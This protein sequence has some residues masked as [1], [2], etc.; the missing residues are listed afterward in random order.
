MK[1]WQHGYDIEYLKQLES[2][3]EHYN[4]YSLSPFAKYKK[5]DIAEDL[6]NKNLVLGDGY[7]YV[8]KTTKHDMP[9]NIYHGVRGGFKR[10]GD[11][12]INRLIISDDLKE[13]PLN[14]F[15]S[16]S[17][18]VQTWAEDL[19]T[20]K[21]LED[22]EFEYICPKVTTFGEIYAF[23]FRE[24]KINN[25]HFGGMFSSFTRN[26]I[27]WDP[28]ENVTLQKV[29]DCPIGLIDVCAN[30]FRNFNYE[31]T[32][33]Y[34]NYNKSR[35]WSAFALRG[36]FD[37][38][39]RIE[40]PSELDK[41]HKTYNPELRDTEIYHDFGVVRTLLFEIFGLANFHRIRFMK[42]EPGGG[43]LSRHT[44]QVDVDCGLQRC[45]ITRFHFPI[46]TN[47]DV[48]FNAWN[49]NGEKISL[50]MQPGSYYILDT[51]KPHMVIN[52]GSTPRIHLVVDV[53]VDKL[54]RS[55]L[56]QN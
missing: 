54:I 18:W 20:R 52:N 35:S 9:I 43:E 51:R 7:A 46:I 6:F 25:P 39:T 37:D 28:I 36:Y 53:V 38:F 21:F 13:N 55:S 45:D 56:C 27:P 44:D 42:L 22:S 17:T 11:V 29:G 19:K 14:A 33:H 16:R 8:S 30:A 34:S 31:F 2:K 49:L 1:N 10:A 4:S 24:A 50:N 41:K 12:L 40:K 26:H 48:E 47:P 15:I 5:N 3:W 32:N 23:Y